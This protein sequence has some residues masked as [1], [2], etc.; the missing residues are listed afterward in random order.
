MPHRDVF[1]L[2]ALGVLLALADGSAQTASRPAPLSIEALRA[3]TVKASLRYVRELDSGPSYTAYL[4]SYR[5]AGLLVYA[6][7]AVPKAAPP[8]RGYPVLVANHGNHPDP[9]KYGMT[10]NGVDSR[11]GDYYRPV[12]ELY[13]K[14][15]FLV[16][17]PD[18]RGHN[19]SE[20]VEFT[21][22]FLAS[23]YF[24]EDV[25]AL[26]SGLGDIQHADTAHVFMWGHSLG[27]EVTLRL[28]L[29]TDSVK[30]AS[31]WSTV[32]GDIWDQAYYY[33]R[34]RNRD[35]PDSSTVEKASISDLKQQISGLGSPYDWTAREPLRHLRYLRTPIVMHHSIGDVGAKFE[36][37]EHLARELYMAGLPYLFYT[38]PGRDHFFPAELREQA[39]DRDVEFF[40]SLID[41]S[42]VRTLR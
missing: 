42:G 23:G 1:V 19:A 35:A 5:S 33:S 26:L 29:A 41:S 7:V 20:G 14:R 13:T 10:A 2:G 16:V 31:L 12:P 38:Y 37:S 4:V 21:R 11:P 30:G 3:G 25:V 22:G 18:Y 15:G 9:P 28:L 24:T 34:S 27:G 36:W 32:G 17:L 40:R 8:P 6:M 39:A